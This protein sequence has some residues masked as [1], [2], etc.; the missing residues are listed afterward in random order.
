MLTFQI[1]LLIKVNHP[2]SHQEHVMYLPVKSFIF[3]YAFTLKIQ[4]VIV[5][6][7]FTKIVLLDEVDD[8][9]D[10][11]ICAAEETY[12]QAE[13]MQDGRFRTAMSVPRYNT[14]LRYMSSIK[15]LNFNN[16]LSMNSEYF[17]KIIGRSGDTKKQIERDT[18][19]Q[20]AIPK[21]GQSGD[22]STD[23]N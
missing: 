7:M 3:I 8:Y 21:K 12:V 15:S 18:K 9:Y 14:P 4:Q 1:Y 22:I 19:T 13:K 10:E 2:S 23:N 6:H 16:Y 11:D 17:A 20:I 5:L